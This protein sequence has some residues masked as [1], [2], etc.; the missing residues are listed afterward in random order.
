M[1]ARFSLIACGVALS[2]ASNA[3]ASEPPRFGRSGDIILSAERLFGVT[4]SRF[5]VG[6]PGRTVTDFRVTALWSDA[7]RLADG[8][9][10][11]AAIP[12][13]AIDGAVGT[14]VTLGAAVG[15]AYGSFASDGRGTLSHFGILAVPRVGYVIPIGSAG[16]VWLRGGVGVFRS[17]A[18][19]TRTQ[20]WTSVVASFD[21]QLVLSLASGAAF[22]IGPVIDVPLT[23]S[24]TDDQ[25]PT[26]RARALAFGLTTALLAHF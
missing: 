24:I 15:V 17:T 22:C 18:K 11:A 10:N 21:P 26:Q 5:S 12:R 13:L 1:S 3:A 6:D 23:G 16:A 8:I 25:R 7:P 14:N 9:P 20:T 19:M 2:T 4:Y